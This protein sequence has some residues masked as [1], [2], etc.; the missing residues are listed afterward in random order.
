MVCDPPRS[1]DQISTPAT[2][3][4]SNGKS[5]LLLTSL[6][7]AVLIATGIF[8]RGATPSQLLSQARRL[9]ASDPDRALVLLET[10][11]RAARSD[12][13]AS[14]LLQCQILASKHRYQQALECFQGIRQPSSCPAEE[15]MRLART[16]H[17]A[18][19]DMLA[20]LACDAAGNSIHAQLDTLR[21]LLEVKYALNRTAQTL[22]LCRDYAVLAPD[23]PLPWLISAGI[24]HENEDRDPAIHAYQ[25]A[26]ARKPPVRET[27]R[28]RYHLVGLLMDVGDLKEA[29]RQC[30]LLLADSTDPTTREQIELRNADLMR[31]EDKPLE[32]MSIVNAV[33]A[34]HVDSTFALQLR[35]FLHFESGETEQAI[36]D[37]SAVVRREPFNQ[38][39]H[40]KLGQACQRQGKIDLARIHL[41]RSQELILLTS[42]ILT[43]ENR[44]RNDPHNRE[45]TL[46]LAELYERRGNPEMAARWRQKANNVK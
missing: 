6:V 28:I 30:D 29:R 41:Q 27:V 9:E 17:S 2:F 21:T 26:L 36:D 22:D 15:L 1:S 19:Y 43:T 32:A 38:S 25:E 46:K 11:I 40:Y 5:L 24:H 14:K 45:L 7:L 31:R 23:D 33:L 35:G 12:A 44:F 34:R 39:A 42:E 18:G 8:L 20:E 4:L 10:A 13:P 16:C 37:L 3:R